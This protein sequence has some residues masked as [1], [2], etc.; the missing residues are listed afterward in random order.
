MKML[1]LQKVHTLKRH[2]QTGG[3]TGIVRAISNELLSL[4]EFYW[5]SLQTILLFKIKHKAYTTHVMT[6]RYMVTIQPWSLAMAY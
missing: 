2:N 5:N 6:Q 4:G 3:A 1:N